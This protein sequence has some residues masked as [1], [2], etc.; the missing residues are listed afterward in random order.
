MD[1]FCLWSDTPTALQ[2]QN[3]HAI[4]YKTS[5]HQ[6]KTSSTLLCSAR[7]VSTLFQKKRNFVSLA[8]F[9]SSSF[10][11][12]IT[13]S[14]L[15]VQWR[16]LIAGNKLILLMRLLSYHR[17]LPYFVL[18]KPKRGITCLLGV[19]NESIRITSCKQEYYRNREWCFY[20]FMWS[21]C[22][23]CRQ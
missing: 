21:G 15:R 8:L 11:C 6:A 18:L 12:L 14:R 19:H 2:L 7:S 4:D 23:W 10:T 22:N 5:L 16:Y 9:L 1:L 13:W 20:M 17:I 3:Y